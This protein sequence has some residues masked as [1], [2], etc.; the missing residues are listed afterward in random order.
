MV[1]SIVHEDDGLLY[2]AFLAV[3]Q[4]LAHPVHE[5]VVVEDA[6]VVL[7]LLPTFLKCST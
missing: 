3:I 6:M 2:L 7:D 1:A 5:V 4:E